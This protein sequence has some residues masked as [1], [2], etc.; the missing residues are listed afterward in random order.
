MTVTLEDLIEL[1]KTLPSSAR[2][3]EERYFFVQSKHP[4][5]R[6]ENDASRIETGKITRVSVKGIGTWVFDGRIEITMNRENG[7]LLNYYKH[8]L[9]AKQKEID[10]LRA[11]YRMVPV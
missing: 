2:I 5:S 1:E 10:E 8:I 11:Y 3:G 6:L 7:D 9:E 4:L